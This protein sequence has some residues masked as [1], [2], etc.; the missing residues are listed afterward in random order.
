MQADELSWI[1]AAFQIRNR[2]LFQPDTSFASQRN[3]IIL[4]LGIIELANG[5]DVN[6]RTVLHNDSFQEIA[7][8]ACSKFQ[9]RRELN[10]LGFAQA[11]PHAGQRFMKAFCAIR[12]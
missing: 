3:V 7:R 6:L 1:E 2:L 4:R 8:S 9:I 5:D 11:G 10:W 12:L